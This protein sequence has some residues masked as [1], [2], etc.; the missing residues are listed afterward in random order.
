[1]TQHIVRL[2]I[3]N[4]VN[5]SEINKW[6]FFNTIEERDIWETEM[7]KEEIDW[8]YHTS[9]AVSTRYYSFSY[10]TPETILEM[11]MSELDGLSLGDFLRL[12][13]ILK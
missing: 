8:N 7:R 9:G 11:S 3:T 12:I 10:Y 1:M 6:M 13:K 2:E 4:S 5:D